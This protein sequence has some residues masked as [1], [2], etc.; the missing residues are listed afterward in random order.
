VT[1]KRD[2]KK[3]MGR[4]GMEIGPFFRVE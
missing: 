3:L 2:Q 1:A 4:F